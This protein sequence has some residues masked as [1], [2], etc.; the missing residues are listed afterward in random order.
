MM[1]NNVLLLH[2]ERGD[3][4]EKKDS[5]TCSARFD[6][7]EHCFRLL[8]GQGALWW[9]GTHEARANAQIMNIG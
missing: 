2:F 9:P 4:R 5:C 7:P 3:I 1:I 8:V 6:H